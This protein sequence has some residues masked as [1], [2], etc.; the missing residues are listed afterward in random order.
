[1]NSNVLLQ[2]TIL[3]NK[4]LF[5]P[6]IWTATDH[7]KFVQTLKLLHKIIKHKVVYILLIVV[8]MMSPPGLLAIALLFHVHPQ[9][10]IIMCLVRKITNAT[11]RTKNTVSS[12][13]ST[14]HPLKPTESVPNS[15]NANTN[16]KNTVSATPSPAPTTKNLS[17]KA[18]QPKIMQL[19]Q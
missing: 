2:N 4:V 6:L 8:I 7:I 17:M 13:N 16:S 14:P 10:L 3:G 5:V 19:S 9:F 15:S 18:N 12:S 11:K 1:M